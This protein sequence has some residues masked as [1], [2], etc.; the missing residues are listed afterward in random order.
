MFFTA[1]NKGLA[2]KLSQ[3]MGA[4]Q[5]SDQLFSNAHTDLV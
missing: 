1:Q 2:T 3:N 5:P 4:E